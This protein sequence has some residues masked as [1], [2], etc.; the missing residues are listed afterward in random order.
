V[1]ANALVFTRKEELMGPK[2]KDSEEI[3]Y[4]LESLLAASSATKGGISSHIGFL[5]E[6]G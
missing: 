2:T 6:Y 5:I 4:L 3:V 1:K